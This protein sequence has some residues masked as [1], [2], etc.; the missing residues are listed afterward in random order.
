LLRPIALIRPVQ[1]DKIFE[2]PVRLLRLT[3]TPTLELSMG[4]NLRVLA[5]LVM[6]GQFFSSIKMYYIEFSVY[7]QSKPAIVAILPSHPLMFS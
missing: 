1:I 7:F 3:V 6:H 5:D 2:S 4:Q